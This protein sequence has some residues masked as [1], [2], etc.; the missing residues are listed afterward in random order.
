MS[1]PQREH[2]EE[3]YI[4]LS[5][6]IFKSKT[7][8]H[9]NAIQKL[10]TIYL[11][12]M[13][14]HKD[15]QWWDK[16]H[17]RFITIKRGS[18]ITS[19]EQIRKK[20]NDRLITTQK[21]RTCVK[22]LKNM[23]FLTNET[24]SGYSH[25][26]II[27]YDFYQDASRYEARRLTSHQQAPNKPLTINNN[28]KNVKN[29]IHSISRINFNYKTKRWENITEEDIKD[30]SIINPNCDVK[31]ELEHMRQWLLDDRRREKKRYRKFIAGWIRRANK[32]GGK[33]KVSVE[34]SLKKLEEEYG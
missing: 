22:I 6:K 24:A 9:L 25:I 31:I 27:K 5:R 11:I 23:Q 15:K 20:I 3:G 26:S 28:V 18:F 4:I 30:W 21:I 14:N 13:A 2:V 17:N 8:S 16:Y 34:E 29:R 19:I 10:I 33:P 7:F 1:D 32:Y 12:L